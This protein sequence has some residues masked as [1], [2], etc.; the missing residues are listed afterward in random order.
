MVLA[1]VG[2]A[3][4]LALGCNDTWEVFCFLFFFAV[5]EG[6]EEPGLQTPEHHCQLQ[7]G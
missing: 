1:Y 4:S 2:L 5:S 7:W 6:F 3:E